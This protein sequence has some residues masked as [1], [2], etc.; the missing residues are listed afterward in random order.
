MTDL[1]LL[2]KQNDRRWASARVTGRL[3]ATVPARRAIANK[4]RYLRIVRRLRE[5]GSTMPDEAW[6]FVAAAHYRESG[7]DFNTHLGQGDPLARNGVPVKTVH[8]PAG[9]GPFV[10]ADAFEQAAV[11]ALWSCAPYAAR[12][13]DWSISAMLTRLER[14]N[15]LAYANQN[16]PSPYVWS[17][18]T[19]YDPPGGPGGKVKVDHGPIMPIVDQQLGVAALLKEIDRLDDAIDLSGQQ[20]PAEPAPDVVD[21]HDASVHDGLW[22]QKSLNRLGATPPLVED[23][24]VGAATRRAVLAF[25]LSH[26][27]R[28]DG[29]AGERETIPAMIREMK[30]LPAA[31]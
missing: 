9:R 24:I 15:G 18:T 25:Q 27:L 3:N 30:N 22:L 20:R 2:Q 23:G 7:Y 17:G 4:D 13:K 1:M 21:H 14:Y 12:Q 26:R 8:V 31:S 19:A 6:V 5:L 28:A 16:R 11:D 29:K 10:G